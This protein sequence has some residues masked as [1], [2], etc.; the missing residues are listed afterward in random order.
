FWVCC[1]GLGRGRWG[2]DGKLTRPRE[3]WMDIRSWFFMFFSDKKGN[4]QI[5]LAAASFLFES[6]VSDQRGEKKVKK[7]GLTQKHLELDL[8]LLSRGWDW[9]NLPK[10]FNAQI[11]EDACNREQVNSETD[12][13]LCKIS[14][15]F[16][17]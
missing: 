3:L 9:S 13:T 6:P 17:S 5:L 11:T 8:Y 7:A 12:A 10:M 2:R 14:R 16:C 1:G 4:V 15:Q